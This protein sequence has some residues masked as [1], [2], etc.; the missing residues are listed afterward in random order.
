LPATIKRKVNRIS[1]PPIV[2]FALIVAVIGLGMA[3][4]PASQAKDTETCGACHDDM[5]KSFAAEPHAALGA[6]SCTACHGSGEKH[7]EEGTKVGIFAF[8]ASDLVNEKSTRCLTCHA[9]DNPQFMTSP[10]GQASLDCTTCHS[11]HGENAASPLLKTKENKMCATCHEDIFALFQLN[12][13][14]RLQ[15]GI[16]TCTTCHDPHAPAT[17]TRLAGFKQE[18]CIKCHT[19][20]GGPF[21][22]EHQASRVEGC[23]ICHEVH[24][25]PNRRMLTFQNI[26]DLCFSCHAEA[27]AWHAN[28]SSEG[29]NCVTCH[30]AIHGSNLDKK[31]LK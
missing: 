31:F 3:A 6:K 13:R 12:E 19:D 15:E 28:F 10:H 22:Y 16:M 17:R 25:S 30:S 11:I 1:L 27:P 4:K 2:L 21:L 29:T 24:G 5:V 9:K 23:T 7:I 18:E 14:H 20:K 26:A 8:A